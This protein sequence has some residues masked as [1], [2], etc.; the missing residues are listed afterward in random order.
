MTENITK[1][2]IKSFGSSSVLLLP[3]N[4]PVTVSM[5]KATNIK[6]NSIASSC[7]VKEKS[8]LIIEENGSAYIS[9][10]VKSVSIMLITAWANNWKYYVGNSVKSDLKDMEY[11]LNKDGNVYHI[12]FPILDPSADGVYVQMCAMRKTMNAYLAIDYSSIKEKVGMKSLSEDTE[13]TESSLKETSTGANATIEKSN[14]KI[15]DGKIVLG[16]LEKKLAPGT[17]TVPIKLMNATDIETPSMASDCVPCA[18]ILVISDDGKAELKTRVLEVVIGKASDV[19]TEWK[20]FQSNSPSGTTLDATIIESRQYTN[21]AGQTNEVPSEISFIIP[22][23]AQSM[24]GVFVNMFI[25]LMGF[26]SSAFIHIDYEKAVVGD[27]VYKGD[28]HI[29]QFGEYDVFVTVSVNGKGLISNVDVTAD[30]FDGSYINTNKRKM[31]TAINGMVKNYV[32]LSAKAT[33]AISEVRYAKGARYS[34]EAIKISI[35]RALNL[36]EEEEEIEVPASP[37]EEGEYTVEIEYFT[38]VVKHSLV[39]YK[40]NTADLHVDSNGKIRLSTFIINGTK[41]EPLYIKKFNGYYENND[42][43]QGKLKEDMEVE[44][45]DTRFRDKYFAKGTKIVKKITFPL[46]GDYA[47]IYYTN[48]NIYVPVMNNLDGEQDG[49][50]YDHGC[51][52]IDCFIKIYW[53]TLKNKATL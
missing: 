37:I 47:L 26:N 8:Y 17:Y 11:E 46:E 31:K 25:G 10:D 20:V 9:L 35:L 28:F 36:E 33:K 53:N 12:K 51:F 2:N 13:S 45:D 38:D 27:L 21:S 22:P 52:D 14:T 23:E 3:G 32:G 39:Q 18:A 43:V 44:M 40:I 24:N 7:I 6:F 48:M 42:I 1:E 4:Y 19:A 16:T 41:T 15:I 50:L 5:M 29:E 34:S 30:N 49:V